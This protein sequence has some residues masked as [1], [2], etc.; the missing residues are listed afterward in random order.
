MDEHVY[1]LFDKV[2]QSLLFHLILHCNRELR[3]FAFYKQI[4]RF[5]EHTT[6]MFIFLWRI[7]QNFTM[8][9]EL[10]TQVS[11]SDVISDEERD[12]QL[13]E[14]IR[15][16]LR[17]FPQKTVSPDPAEDEA[18]RN[19]A[20]QII[21]E[22]SDYSAFRMCI[23]RYLKD[24]DKKMNDF[25]VLGITYNDLRYYKAQLKFDSDF[26]SF[27]SPLARQ[28]LDLIAEDYITRKL[29]REHGS[30]T[31]TLNSVKRSIVVFLGSIQNC[32]TA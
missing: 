28:T 27:N 14:V 31:G 1:S 6:K 8:I 3:H 7:Q 30:K 26:R 18:N 16:E 9:D 20:D 2:G 15:R 24:A 12:A 23:H 21:S 11:D 32:F 4:R 13:D 5:E 17:L 25:R 19:I 22:G 10:A 29:M